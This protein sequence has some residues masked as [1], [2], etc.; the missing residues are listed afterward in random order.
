MC[1]PDEPT[2]YLALEKVAEISSTKSRSRT[3]G[4]DTLEYK[5][6]KLAEASA[7][8]RQATAFESN[9]IELRGF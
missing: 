1:S 5:Q 8:K 9:R 4:T 3:F 7:C 6:A 2:E